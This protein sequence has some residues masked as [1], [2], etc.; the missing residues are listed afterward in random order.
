M[1]LDLT[2]SP[3]HDKLTHFIPVTG[4]EG[5]KDRWEVASRAVG[6]ECW[7]IVD[8][9]STNWCVGFHVRKAECRAQTHIT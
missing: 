5:E 8:G 6:L 4:S 9:D 1:H 7:L 2:P 3:Y